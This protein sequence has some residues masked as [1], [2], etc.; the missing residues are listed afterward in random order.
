MKTLELVNAI[1]ATSA[2]IAPF[3]NKVSEIKIKNLIKENEKKFFNK[4][5]SSQDKKD[6]I[7]IYGTIIDT[8][9]SWSFK[10]INYAFKFKIFKNEF[11][12]NNIFNSIINN[13]GIYKQYAKSKSIIQKR[14]LFSDLQILTIENWLNK[15]AR[16]SNNLSNVDY[17][18]T[19]SLSV[20]SGLAFLA[21]SAILTGGISIFPVIAGF[22][23]TGLLVNSGLHTKNVNQLKNELNNYYDELS[24]ILIIIKTSNDKQKEQKLKQRIKEIII[25]VNKL[26]NNIIDFNEFEIT[27]EEVNSL[28][29]YIIGNGY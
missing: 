4:A 24:K 29:D 14:S 17:E 20:G 1:Q 12:K 25:N 21:I 9:S 23:G 27:N 10:K 28:T 11:E 13:T 3:N 26:S 6:F 22:L 19:I 7:N 18:N 8:L 5:T 15:I 2:I 16:Y